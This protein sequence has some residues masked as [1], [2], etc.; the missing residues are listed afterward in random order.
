[1]FGKSDLGRELE[2]GGARL[3]SSQAHHFSAPKLERKWGRKGWL[4]DQFSLLLLFSFY[5]L[6]V[7]WWSCL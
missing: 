2:N 4:A 5:G 1:V 6:F 7:K 3:F